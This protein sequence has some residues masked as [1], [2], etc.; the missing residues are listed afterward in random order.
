MKKVKEKRQK[1]GVQTF[2][3]QGSPLLKTGTNEQMYKEVDAMAKGI[4]QLINSRNGRDKLKRRIRTRKM[5][6]QQ[7]SA[8]QG[9][10]A[11][12]TG[13]HTATRD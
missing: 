10:E 1:T 5:V 9:D 8:C 3:T 11:K 12:D 4:H 7:P 2:D 6:D 13:F